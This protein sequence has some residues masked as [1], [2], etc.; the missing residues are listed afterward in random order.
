MPTA[1]ETTTVIG[2]VSSP[3]DGTTTST[4]DDKT[5]N[6]AAERPGD[7]DTGAAIPAG[8]TD[9]VTPP[10]AGKGASNKAA[11]AK[12]SAA[13]TGTQQPGSRA[14]A[15]QGQAR[16]AAP[17]SSP[18]TAEAPLSINSIV[19]FVLSALGF[20]LITVPVGL[21]LGYRGVEETTHGKRAGLPFAKWAIYLGWA[22]VAFWI[23]ALI[24]YLWI[25]L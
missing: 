15:P 23:L 8:K 1:S 25:L 18:H 14:G 4:R 5:K 9:S 20:L 6:Q 11:T 13:N 22:W 19:G 16:K 24:T 17:A 12:A 10:P 7:R 21:W 2:G 3:A